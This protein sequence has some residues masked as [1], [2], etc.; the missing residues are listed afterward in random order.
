MMPYA[1]LPTK[2]VTAVLP[3]ML[4]TD[5]ETAADFAARVEAMMQLRMDELVA[6][7]RPVIG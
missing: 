7:R 6:G 1:P 4:P 5:G 2:L 3:P